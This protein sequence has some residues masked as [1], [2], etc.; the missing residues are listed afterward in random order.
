M[1][2]ETNEALLA[3][4]LITAGCEPCDDRTPCSNLYDEEI[5]FKIG[6]GI[7]DHRGN[8]TK[9]SRF[10]GMGLLDAA[11][12]AWKEEAKGDV[13]FHIRQTPRCLEL[14]KAYR[15]QCKEIE[16]SS[17]KA[18]DLL[19]RVAD[20]FKTGAIMPDEFILRTA[21]VNLKT[22]RDF[23]N[24]WKKMVPLLRVPRKGKSVMIE[25]T[26]TVP[27]KGG[28]TRTVPA[29]AVTSPGFDVISLNAPSKMRKDMGF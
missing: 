11:C 8:I 22:R 19:L 26:A 4:C 12:K 7:K 27:Q 3:F 23:M 21:C 20:E 15:E 14:I 25:T 17:L 18:S 24:H 13:R 10:A 5:L 1:P 16:E 29:K 2:F 28:G 6:G 9:P